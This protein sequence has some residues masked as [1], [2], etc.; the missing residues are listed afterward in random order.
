MLEILDHI[1]PIFRILKNNKF[2]IFYCFFVYC[3]I[4]AFS[5]S[6]S[7]TVPPYFVLTGLLFPILVTFATYR[8]FFL[9]VVLTL[10]FRQERFLFRGYTPFD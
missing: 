8:N 4:R 10:R 6:I 7:P 2:F 5:G 3:T 9:P 1:Y